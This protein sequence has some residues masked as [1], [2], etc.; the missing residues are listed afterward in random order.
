MVTPAIAWLIFGSCLCLMELILPTAF[1]A[2]MMGISAILVSAAALIIP[3]TSIQMILWLILSSLLVFGFRK[4]LRPKH[5][6]SLLQ[7]EQ[8]GKTLTEITSNKAGRVMYEGNS[9]RALCADENITIPAEKTVYIVSRIGNTL[10]V[11]PAN[12]LEN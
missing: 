6:H 8:E 9:W 3:N 4:Y 1:V 11:L 7:D 2:F 5:S 12:I 10:F